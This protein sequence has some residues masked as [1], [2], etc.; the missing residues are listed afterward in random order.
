[1]YMMTNLETGAT[2]NGKPLI[3]VNAKLS[4]IHTHRP[5]SVSSVDV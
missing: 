1:M 4:F 2:A 5:I 3:D